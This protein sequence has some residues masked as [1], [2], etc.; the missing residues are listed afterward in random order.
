MNAAIVI[1][2]TGLAGYMLAK[3]FR[4]RDAQSS[5]ILITQSDGTFYSKPLLST[6]LI[7]NK[8]VDQLCIHVVDVMRQELN[9]TILTRTGVTSIDALNKNIVCDDGKNIQYDKLILA[10]GAEK[11]KIPLSGD[12]VQT[13]LSVNNL[14]DYRVF[15]KALIGKKHIAILGTGL[16]GCEFAN[17]LI[18]AGFLVS[19]I[20]PDKSVLQQWVP[21]CV[22]NALQNA[23]QIMGVTFHLKLFAKKINHANSGCDIILS[24]G[25]KIK[26][27]L[28]FSA[29]GIKPDLTLAQS[30][31]V[32]TNRGVVVDAHL[33]TSDP[34]IYALGDCAEIEGELKMV[35]AILLQSARVLAGV[36]TGELQ[37]LNKTSVPIAVKTS[38]CPIVT[39]PPPKNQVGE[40]KVESDHNN[41]RALF[42][43]AGNQLRGFALSGTCVKD[44]AELLRAICDHLLE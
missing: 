25:Q 37:A 8:T 13:V 1:I 35:V 23:L 19:V 42:Y 10:N 6:A 43:D 39:V 16:V 33:Q 20:A 2:G 18:H 29:V 36:L 9:A 11:I 31:G 4:K 30:A 41:V 21:E 14:D 22:G 27:D 38:A 26:A 24:D 12:A 17:D 40:W 44:K 32:K 7:N 28:V 34:H 5:L 15:R 3:E